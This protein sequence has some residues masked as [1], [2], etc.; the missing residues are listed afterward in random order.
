MI[1]F[2]PFQEYNTL[3]VMAGA[4]LLG[5][6]AGML[7]C[8]AVLRRKA[9]TGDALAH[10]AL[11]GLCAAFILLG[12]RSLPEMLLGAFV[13]GLLSIT[14]ITAI[15]RYTRIKEDATIGI[16]LSV[17]FGVG[18]TENAE[19]VGEFQNI[20]DR[21]P[22]SEEKEI[23]LQTLSSISFPSLPF[24][25]NLAQFPILCRLQ[26]VEICFSNEWMAYQCFYFLFHR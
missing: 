14:A 10:A 17:F 15:T 19:K 3:V 16:V 22:Q 13:S 8:F 11:P 20:V 9:L 1:D 6:C 25:Q 23:L 4:T 7:G 18:Y 12:E 26:F 21:R 2:T 24:F 5:A